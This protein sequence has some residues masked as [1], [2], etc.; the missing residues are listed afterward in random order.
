MSMKGRLPAPTAPTSLSGDLL[1]HVRWFGVGVALGL[2]PFL[3]ALPI[4]GF[5]ALLSIYPQFMRGWL[6]PLA[7][8]LMGVLAALVEFHSV[9]LPSLAS[10]RRRFSWSLVVW[11]AAFV[12]LALLYPFLVTRVSLGDGSQVEAFVTGTDIVPSRP[13]GSLCECPEGQ[14]AE[15]CIGSIGIDESRI[16]ECFGS[17]RVTLGSQ[18]LGVLYLLLTGS[19]MLVVGFLLL[20]RKKAADRPAPILRRTESPTPSTSSSDERAQQE[21]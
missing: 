6:L 7:G 16:K 14:S 4:P 19:F 9:R 20:L 2:A 18:I 1:R 12:S 17:R 8:I 10:L 15:R 3:G 5:S 13:P 21:S 11:F